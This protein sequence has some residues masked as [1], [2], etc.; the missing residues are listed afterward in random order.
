[1][2]LEKKGNLV[3]GD[4]GATG[5]GP[6]CITLH[7]RSITKHGEALAFGTSFA[8]IA[9]NFCVLT[10][11]HLGMEMRIRFFGINFFNFRD[12]PIRMMSLFHHL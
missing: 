2:S 5:G 4:L 7:T 11:L 6:T 9:F 10:L 8:L 1:M 12:L 3:Q